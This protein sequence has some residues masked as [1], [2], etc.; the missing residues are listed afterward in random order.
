MKFVE[1]VI[2]MFNNDKNENKNN[3]VEDFKTEQKVENKKYEFRRYD[4]EY[5]ENCKN[6]LDKYKE[7]CSNKNN[8][9]FDNIG[10]I[11]TTE[12]N[13][14]TDFKY[15]FNDS[16]NSCVDNINDKIEEYFNKDTNSKEEKLVNATNTIFNMNRTDSP[17]FY[18]RIYP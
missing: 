9:S 2:G 4:L 8:L 15:I 10:T 13:N 11:N 18:R 3:S 14:S 7:F 6:R 5:F 16:N 1:R 17:F 12:E